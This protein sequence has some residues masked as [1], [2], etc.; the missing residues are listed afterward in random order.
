MCKINLTGR[1]GQQRIWCNLE[2][3]LTLN[4]RGANGLTLNYLEGMV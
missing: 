2:N 3:G 1:S 4:Y